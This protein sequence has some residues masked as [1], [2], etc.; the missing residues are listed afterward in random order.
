MNDPAFSDSWR[1]CLSTQ[2]LC[3]S[4]DPIGAQGTRIASILRL[5]MLDGASDRELLAEAAELGGLFHAL[6]TSIR[7]TLG[8]G[9][10]PPN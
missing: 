10:E 6:L 3:E 5:R 7:V 9:P 1:E 4:I 8:T 2:E